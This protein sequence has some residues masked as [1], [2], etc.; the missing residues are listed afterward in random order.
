MICVSRGGGRRRAAARQGRQRRM[1]QIRPQGL[2][3]FNGSL[4]SG[5]FSGAAARIRTGDLIL[6]NRPGGVFGCTHSCPRI[7]SKALYCKGLGGFLLI[8]DFASCCRI[9][10]HFTRFVGK[11]VGKPGSAGTEVFAVVKGPHSGL[12]LLFF[13]LEIR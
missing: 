3:F 10:G 8:I 7:P 11:L 13:G 2:S 12:T 9:S 4:V 5:T 6:T 1:A